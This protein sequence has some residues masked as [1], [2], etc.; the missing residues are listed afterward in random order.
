MLPRQVKVSVFLL[1]NLHISTKK[2]RFGR[3]IFKINVNDFNWCCLSLLCNNRMLI[4]LLAKWNFIELFDLFYSSI[5][6]PFYNLT[7]STMSQKFVKHQKKGI[8]II[9]I[10]LS[11]NWNC[12]KFY[13]YPTFYMMLKIFTKI[14]I[15]RNIHANQVV[16]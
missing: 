9:W 1:R 3:V 13:T 11:V 2:S 8:T 10:C 14:M 7:T 12:D 16:M 6:R 5:M 4:V 15:L